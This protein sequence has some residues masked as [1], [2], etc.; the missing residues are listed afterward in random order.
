MKLLKSGDSK[1]VNLNQVSNIGVDTKKLRIIFNLKYSINVFDKFTPDYVYFE[2][3]DYNELKKAYNNLLELVRD[4][5]LISKNE[6]QRLVSKKCVSSINIIPE[7]KRIIFNLNYGITHPNDS[8]KITSDFV[9]WTFKNDE[10]FQKE[11]ENLNNS[12]NKI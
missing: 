10:N 11:V 5:F 12:L 6:N 9:F 4:D 1:I 3:K 7:Q 2:Y 8:E